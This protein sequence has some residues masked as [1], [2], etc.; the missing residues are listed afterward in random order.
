[1]T[2]I[3][4][5]LDDVRLGRL[6]LGD[7]VTQINGRGKIDPQ[8][9][10][11]EIEDLDVLLRENNVDPRLHRAV[12][13]KLA[14]LQS[15]PAA[16]PS[17]PA[18][19]PPTPQD[20]TVFFVAPTPP[21][22]PAAPDEDEDYD[23]MGGTIIS[24]VSLLPTPKPPSPPPAAPPTPGPSSTATGT[25]PRP[26]A[27]PSSTTTQTGSRPPAAPPPPTTPPSTTTQT[28]TRPPPRPPTPPADAT[29]M[30]SPPG[31][32]DATRMVSPRS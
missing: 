13:T 9:H 16:R 1:M 31:N 8:E 4:Q 2:K 12:K 22:P 17:A 18:A 10:L 32:N 28:G 23:P 27:Q 24:P 20:R 14:E 21:T 29:V 6:S 25:G 5:W 15:A 30:A 7:L 3:R 26:P 11:R 19:T